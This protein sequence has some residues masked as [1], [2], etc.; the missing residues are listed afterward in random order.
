MRVLS[1]QKGDKRLSPFLFLS[2]EKPSF[3][4]P[5]FSNVLFVTLYC[6]KNQMFN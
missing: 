1:T 6:N 3:F 2:A 5:S 4:C